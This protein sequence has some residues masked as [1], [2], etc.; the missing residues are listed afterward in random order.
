MSSFTAHY[1]GELST[2]GD[3]KI[4]DFRFFF[5]SPITIQKGSGIEFKFSFNKGG[6]IPTPQ[7]I[8][9]TSDLN[10]LQC[11]FSTPFERTVVMKNA[12]KENNVEPGKEV[13][14]EIRD[15]AIWERF[16]PS[17][18]QIDITDP[19]DNEL[20]Y[21]DSTSQTFVEIPEIK[22]LK[23]YF[24]EKEEYDITN[25]YDL[26]VEYEVPPYSYNEGDP[27][28]F[29]F[30]TD[31]ENLDL[32]EA[33]VGSRNNQGLGNDQN[34]VIATGR[35]S[36]RIHHLTIKNVVLK[37]WRSREIPIRFMALRKTS[38][39]D[40]TVIKV[41]TTMTFKDKFKVQYEAEKKEILSLDPDS[42]VIKHIQFMEQN[43]KKHNIDLSE[44]SPYKA[45]YD[46]FVKEKA[47]EF[48]VQP[49]EVEC[50]IHLD[51][52][53][54]CRDLTIEKYAHKLHPFDIVRVLRGD[55]DPNAETPECL[56]SMSALELV[57][58]ERSG[59]KIIPSP[60]S[61]G[62]EQTYL[63]W[64]YSYRDW[65]EIKK[66]G[67]L[68][69]SDTE[70][71]DSNPDLPISAK[72]APR[73]RF[74]ELGDSHDEKVVKFSGKR[75]NKQLIPKGY[76]SDEFTPTLISTYLED[77]KN[78]EVVSEEEFKIRIDL[79]FNLSDKSIIRVLVP[80]S[81]DFSPPGIH[82]SL[83]SPTG[84]CEVINE[85]LQKGLLVTEL[86]Q[87]R[88][89]TLE[90]VLKLQNK[91]EIGRPTQFEV[92]VG[93]KTEKCGEKVLKF[94]S[95]T[96]DLT[97]F[98]AIRPTFNYFDEE[99]RLEF[100]WISKKTYP[101]GFTAILKQDQKKDQFYPKDPL[102]CEGRYSH[103]FIYNS[104]SPLFSE[105]CEEFRSD[106]IVKIYG[107][108]EKEVPS[109]RL[110]ILTLGSYVSPYCSSFLDLNLRILI[111]AQNGKFIDK[112]ELP[113]DKEKL[114]FN[115]KKLKIRARASTIT[116]ANN[117]K[118]QKVKFN[119]KRLDFNGKLNLRIF[120]PNTATWSDG[121]LA[122][123]LL[124]GFDGI[125]CSR[126]TGSYNLSFK[127]D[128]VRALSS[129]EK[130]SLEISG[131]HLPGPGPHTIKFVLGTSWGEKCDYANREVMVTFDE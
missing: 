111:L 25:V 17:E 68:K 61:G 41:S 118:S 58:L 129:S 21:I 42:E 97:T 119:I 65:V 44:L 108:P 123:N 95:Y 59:L 115:K 8:G 117:K 92:F 48:G 35:W 39:G 80:T 5:K 19:K 49:E 101:A 28:V 116:D 31:S 73:S 9:K 38:L 90:I 27:F 55:Q 99:D 113:L 46:S 60:T 91:K 50:F 52:E 75:Q 4:Y 105:S 76:D 66:I 13:S 63:S 100:L 127:I 12:F 107:R 23:I 1:I 40:Q 112:V 57:L 11:S 6:D 64:P 71:E 69:I 26:E 89:K 72:Y 83:K 54:I 78:L 122:C 126:I 104:R 124:S 77:Q 62:L 7:C 43:K 34:R 22:K 3:L 81:I 131:F 94:R 51:G 114:R 47:E 82:C 16:E 24:A 128:S 85:R 87:I 121:E 88:S 84:K 2:P 98:E 110:M 32:R 14:F 56:Q 10:G 15:L 30:S 37:D 67:P 103:R 53:Y 93:E 18:I 96:Y 70:S 109:G 120:F 29:E 125:T 102:N 86:G 74:R 45:S 36:G 79:D 20:T 130:Y 33:W 106:P